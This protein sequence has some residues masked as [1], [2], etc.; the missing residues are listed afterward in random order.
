[1]A[2]M[3]MC[4]FASALALISVSADQTGTTAA[5]VSQSFADSI[6]LPNQ[7]A[8]STLSVER[9][10]SDAGPQVFRFASASIKAKPKEEFPRQKFRDEEEL[11]SLEDEVRDSVDSRG[12]D[13]APLNL[14]RIGFP[15]FIQELKR[16][17]NVSNVRSTSAQQTVDFISIERMTS[18]EKSEQIAAFITTICEGMESQGQKPE[19]VTFR[20]FTF[21]PSP[22]FSVLVTTTVEAQRMEQS[23]RERL[24]ERRRGNVSVIVES[25]AWMSPGTP[26]PEISIRAEF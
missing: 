19:S 18:D 25:S 9:S 26:R 1:M 20:V 2:G 8:S 16:Y 23:I 22:A 5:V 7:T 3:L 14:D 4:V 12:N 13:Q 17:R 6:Q 15:H 21:A 11:F 24:A 10:A